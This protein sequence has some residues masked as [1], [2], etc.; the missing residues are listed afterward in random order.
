MD[1]SDFVICTM[2]VIGAFILG[3]MFGCIIS[4]GSKFCPECGEEYPKTVSYCRFDGTELLLKG[5]H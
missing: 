2:V 1:G 5:E 3:I 4:D